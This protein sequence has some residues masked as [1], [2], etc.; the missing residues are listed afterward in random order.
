[1]HKAPS[2]VWSWCAIA[3]T[4]AAIAAI[5]Q[6]HELTP[7]GLTYLDMAT[8]CVE[9]GPASLINTMWNPLY[10]AFLAL[11]MGTLRPSPALV[12]P[13][14]H[15]A[16]WLLFA[17]LAASFSLLLATWTRFSNFGNS[18]GSAS[19]TIVSMFGI[20]V[21][22]AP[23]QGFRMVAGLNPD[24]LLST[25]VFLAAWC[26]IRI[27]TKS[28]RRYYI[29][30]GVILALGF[31]SKPVGLPTGFLL[32]AILLAWPPKGAT[33]ARLLIALAVFGVATSPL[34]LAISYR[35]GHFTTSESG[36]LNYVWHVNDFYPFLGWMGQQSNEYGNPAHPPRVLLEKPLI[37]E[38]ASPVP[39]TYPLWYE[40]SY[41][42]AGVHPHFDA[43]RQMAAVIKNLHGLY[44]IA[45]AFPAL[46]A[47]LIALAMMGGWQQV[48]KCLP[49]QFPWMAAWGSLAAGLYSAVHLEG[50]YLAPFVVLFALGV[51]LALAR[52]LGS[53]ANPVLLTLSLVIILTTAVSSL[54]S[55]SHTIKER[56]NPGDEQRIADRLAMLGM[57]PG[58]RIATAGDSSDAYW[59]RQCGVRIV[60]QALDGQ[61]FRMM[62][63][64]QLQ[65]L[66]RKLERLHVKAIVARGDPP[67]N[68]ERWLDLP[69][70]NAE[71]YRVLL[72]P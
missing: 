53:A 33:R 56:D 59:A 44:G 28:S 7:D 12:I 50:R 57:R 3:V 49:G 18:P 45:A 54:T 48:R 62:A 1:V 65:E 13:V 64:G 31:Y 11:W 36:S 40:P 16:T 71:P 51:F 2:P 47:G 52:A 6:R 55:L 14:A 58:D 5:D 4:V 67:Q 46:W 72:I 37:L 39:G 17:I 15:M 8:E 38:F 29:L 68:S 69:A 22:F 32:L 60:A 61:Q 10:P 35:A 41:W 42:Y 19:P 23:F 63:D 25:C 66:I 24:L 34:I 21:F 26:C 9:A 27:I 30:L 20:C 43:K 70:R